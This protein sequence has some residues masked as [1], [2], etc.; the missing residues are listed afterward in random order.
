MVLSEISSINVNLR[1]EQITQLLAFEKFFE[2]QKQFL[3][4][5]K[6]REEQV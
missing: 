5:Q 3:K 2:N 6:R 4:R 1:T